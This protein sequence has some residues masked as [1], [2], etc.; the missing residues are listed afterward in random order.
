MISAFQTRR[1]TRFTWLLTGLLLILL[2]SP[3]FADDNLIINGDF[4]KQ[5][6]LNK[7]TKYPAESR[8]ADWF[9]DSVDGGYFSGSA[10]LQDKSPGNNGHALILHQCIEDIDSGL[11]IHFG[12]I[13]RVDEEEEPGVFATVR[14]EEHQSDDC[15]DRAPYSSHFLTINARTD[16]WLGNDKRTDLKDETV[17][18][19]RISLSV[20]KSVGTGGKGKVYFDNVWLK[21]EASPNIFDDRFEK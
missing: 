16:D 8:E 19:V 2:A 3:A 21:Q 18:S 13:A 9:P 5:L 11:P 6:Q 10:R 1:P 20:K 7:W 4:R 12:A 17:Q 15:S 14:V